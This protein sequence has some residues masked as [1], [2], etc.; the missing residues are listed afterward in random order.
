MNNNYDKKHIT[1]KPEAEVSSIKKSSDGITGEKNANIDKEIIEGDIYENEIEGIF[2]KYTDNIDNKETI[3]VATNNEITTGDAY[4]K[5]VI[6]DSTIE[7]FKINIISIDEQDPTK[8][9]YFEIID[10]KL[11]NKTGG[12]VQGMSGSPIIQNNKIIGVVNYVVV[13]DTNKGYGIFITS[14][15]KEGDELITN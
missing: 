5:T 11:I 12:I 10:N 13:E 14:M 1:N 3:L 2:G 9:I 8:N 15:L 7:D 4:I 6:K